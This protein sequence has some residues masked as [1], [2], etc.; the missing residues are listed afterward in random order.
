MYLTWNIEFNWDEVRGD[1]YKEF[2]LGQSLKIGQDNWWNRGQSLSGVIKGREQGKLS[3]EDQQ[4]RLE[5]IR[6]IKEQEQELMREALYVI[7][8]SQSM[9]AKKD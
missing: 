7:F 3:K 9:D 6:R 4:K 1:K 2:Y 8:I 5:E